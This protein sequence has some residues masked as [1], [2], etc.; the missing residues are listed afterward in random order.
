LLL[1][2]SCNRAQTMISAMHAQTMGS[3]GGLMGDAIARIAA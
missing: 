1:R 2:R 3:P